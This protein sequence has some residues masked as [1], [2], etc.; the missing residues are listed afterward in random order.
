MSAHQS[1][2]RSD[3]SSD[4]GVEDC[5]MFARDIACDLSE[6]HRQSPI[7]FRLVVEHAAYPEH[8]DAL[9]A[10]HQCS[11]EFLVGVRPGFI[12]TGGVSGIALGQSLQP[13][14]GADQ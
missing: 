6:W 11:V 14:E 4:S 13:M 5:L 9:A 12:E 3:I 10:C 8:P 2:G 1:R 7:S